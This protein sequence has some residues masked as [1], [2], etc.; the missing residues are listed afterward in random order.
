MPLGAL[1]CILMSPLMFWELWGRPLELERTHWARHANCNLQHIDD[2]TEMLLGASKSVPLRR[3]GGFDIVIPCL[4]TSVSP[5]ENCTM[6]DFTNTVAPN[7]PTDQLHCC[8]PQPHRG[9]CSG[10]PAERLHLLMTSCSTSSPKLSGAAANI[11]PFIFLSISD[12]WFV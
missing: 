3:H 8:R 7:Y 2:G 1:G 12:P 5:P 11:F 6:L 10:N 9:H 4:V